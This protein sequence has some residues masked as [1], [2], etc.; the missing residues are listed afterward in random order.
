MLPL[1]RLTYDIISI[2]SQ[3]VGA[4]ACKVVNDKVLCEMKS[5]SIFNKLHRICY[6]YTQFGRTK[7]G[8]FEV[9]KLGGYYIRMIECYN[10]LS[11]TE[12]LGGVR[13]SN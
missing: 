7:N 5:N 9:Y 6:E 4:S 13:F 1:R 2:I 3:F 8:I 11:I 10:I 12:G